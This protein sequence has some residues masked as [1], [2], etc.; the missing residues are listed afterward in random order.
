MRD[1]DRFLK[2][3][4]SGTWYYRRQVPVAVR[5]LVNRSSLEISLKTKSL[6]VARVRRDR[7]I[8]F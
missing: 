6:D 4:R 8:C 7:T 3:H 1:K 2:C 5:D